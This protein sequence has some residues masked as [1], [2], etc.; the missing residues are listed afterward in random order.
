MSFEEMQ[1]TMQFLLQ[2]QTKNAVI[3]ERHE[4]RMNGLQENF[5][6]LT[7]LAQNH[8]ERMDA[9]DERTDSLEQHLRFHIESLHA[10]LQA[11]SENFYARLAADRA[12]SDA[13]RAADNEVFEARLAAHNAAFDARLLT[14]YK[15]I[16]ERL[17]RLSAIVER[18]VEKS[19][20]KP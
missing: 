8:D 19:D 13:K 16:D 6:L 14:Q 5:L 1:S 7:Q 12:D 4:E 11:Q 3:L 10:H 2:Q 17:D 20:Q 15:G 18:H 9:S